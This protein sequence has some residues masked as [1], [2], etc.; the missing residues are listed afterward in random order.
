M[1][2]IVFLTFA[3]TT[4]LATSCSKEAKLNRKIDGTWKIKTV[5]G[6]AVSE[7]DKYTYAF[8]KDKKGKGDF[9]ASQGGFSLS[10]TYQLIDDEQIILNTT[11]FGETDADTLKVVEY[12]KNVLK[13]AESDGTYIQEFEIVK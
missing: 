13:L 3:C 6:V 5:E 10:G 12:S 2:K 4:I 1:K 7:A 9:V 8:E 11:F